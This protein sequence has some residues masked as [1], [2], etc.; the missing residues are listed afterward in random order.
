M[1]F[2]ATSSFIAA[3]VLIPTGIYTIATARHVDGRFIV[4]AAFPVLFGIQQTLEGVLWLQI[5]GGIAGAPQGMALGS[6][7]GFL[8]F[9]YLVWP[10]LVPLAAWRIE[11]DPWRRRLLGVTAALGGFVGASL[12]VPVLLHPDWL[13]IEV[14][15][16]SIMYHT[17]LI[18]YPYIPPDVG[19]LLYALLVILPLIA[20]SD[21]M[22]RTFGVLIL[23]SVLISAPIFG[24]AFVSIWCFFAAGLS[25]Y[26]AV[27]LPERVNNAHQPLYR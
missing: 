26:L 18:Y 12:F 19:R 17:R 7:L 24:Y 20:S 5:A 10:G 23:A 27:R 6:A 4:L 15:R 16:G 25:V 11:D 8:F 21:R 22:A 2:N 1:C 13:Q 14:L 9:A 3:G